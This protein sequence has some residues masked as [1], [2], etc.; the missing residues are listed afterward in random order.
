MALRCQVVHLVGFNVSAW[1]QNR[2][3]ACMRIL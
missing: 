3:K 1:Q 2:L